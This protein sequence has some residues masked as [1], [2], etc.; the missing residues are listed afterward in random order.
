MLYK[1]LRVTWGD[2]SFFVVNVVNVAF[3]VFVVL[4]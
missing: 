3:V 1:L 2:D 4:G